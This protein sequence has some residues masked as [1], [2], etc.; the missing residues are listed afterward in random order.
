MGGEHNIRRGINRPYKTGFPIFSLHAPYFLGVPVIVLQ[1][2]EEASTLDVIWGEKW[3]SL[4][5]SL[6]PIFS[7]GKLKGMMEPMADEVDKYIELLEKESL[8]GKPICIKNHLEGKL[9]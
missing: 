7:S 4:R 6:S 2:P 8:N 3:R 1:I 5:K 9:N